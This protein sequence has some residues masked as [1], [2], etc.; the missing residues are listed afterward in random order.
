[1]YKA[2]PLNERNR[3]KRQSRRERQRQ[4]STTAEEILWELADLRVEVADVHTLVAEKTGKLEVQIANVYTH[5]SDVRASL[6]KEISDLKQELKGDNASLKQELK[7][8]I[9]NLRD[10]LKDEIHQ[11]GWKQLMWIG[12]IVVV[13]TFASQY[14]SK[15]IGG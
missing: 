13:A 5:I 15:F 11:A 6:S 14:A 12:G 7:G 2:Q 10:S 4:G 1:M 8:D 9:S 3:E